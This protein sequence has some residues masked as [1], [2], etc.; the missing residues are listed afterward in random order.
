LKPRWAGIPPRDC[1]ATLCRRWRTCPIRAPEALLARRPD[2]AAAEA[3]LAAAGYSA[4]AARKALYP[5]LT[6]RASLSDAAADL[7]DAFDLDNLVREVIGSISAPIFQGGRLRAERDRAAAQAEQLAASLVNT[8]L[9]ALREA[10]NAIDADQRLAERVAALEVA[11]DEPLKP[12][13][14]S[15]ASTPRVW[16]RFL[17]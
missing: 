2:I 14:W 8:A 11:A 6:V 17:S 9:T 10:E 15:S 7:E 16:R 13:R 3:R 5:G 12:W 1:A 4:D